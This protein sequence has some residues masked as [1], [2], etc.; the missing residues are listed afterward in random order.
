MKL[1]YPTSCRLECSLKTHELAL[2]N[3]GE[4]YGFQL[5][6]VIYCLLQVFVVRG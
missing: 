4:E 6:K 2:L 5:P 3:S 1:R